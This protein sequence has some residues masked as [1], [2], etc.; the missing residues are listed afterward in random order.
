M[1]CTLIDSPS[2]SADALARVER[3]GGS[4]KTIWRPLPQRAQRAG[5]RRGDVD[6]VEANAA[7]VRR[8]QAQAGARDGR[9]AAARF[10]DDAERLA[11]S[12][13]ERNAIEGADRDRLRDRPA[14]PFLEGLG[15]T[16]HREQGRARQRFV[17][18]ARTQQRTPCA[19]AAASGINGGSSAHRSI[20]SGQRDWKRQPAGR[21]GS[22]GTWPGIGASASAERSTRGIAAS[23][24][25]L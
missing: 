16:A 17:H 2:A 12:D 7:R 11:A 19:G 25:S 8:D 5:A 10:A 13:V 18:G 24:A 15:E 21:S 22:V 3:R 6:A 14:A 20:R 9:L 1:P 23:S 4:W